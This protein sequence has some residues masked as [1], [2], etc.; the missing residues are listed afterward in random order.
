ML[1][2]LP[3]TQSS[4]TATRVQFS[5]S[6]CIT[7]IERRFPPSLHSY[8]PQM[9]WDDFCDQVDEAL[10]P[11]N[12]AQ[13][14][15]WS[16]GKCSIIT[17]GIFVILQVIFYATLF[18]GH[19]LFPYMKENRILGFIPIYFMVGFLVFCFIIPWVSSCRLS[20]IQNSV[21]ETLEGICK[22]YTARFP[23][24]NIHYRHPI[25]EWEGS[26]DDARAV[27]KAHACIE[28]DISA[29]TGYVNS[30]ESFS[31]NLLMNT[32]AA[33]MLTTNVKTI[34]QRMAELESIRSILSDQEYKD[35]RDEIMS[36]V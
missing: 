28:F 1:L 14:Q 11:S 22:E 34:A 21:I 2:P 25:I 15:A 35:K 4:P 8:L 18:T 24:L 26:G 23:S 9:S 30:T 16:I 20:V 32:V 6:G 5:I 31:P 13:R 12:K 10:M 19:P 36:Q 17:F 33:P 3:H 7:T 29:S 27:V